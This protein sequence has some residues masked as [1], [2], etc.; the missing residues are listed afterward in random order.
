MRGDGNLHPH[1]LLDPKD[2]GMMTRVLAAGEAILK[3]CLAVGGVLSGEHGI[4]IEKSYFM[5]LMFSET[6][7]AVMR[8]LKTVFDPQQIGQSR[9]NFPDTGVW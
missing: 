2:P 1:I 9:E 6:E 5:T 8:R 7:L 3:A 4:G